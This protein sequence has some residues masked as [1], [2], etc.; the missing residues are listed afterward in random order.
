L[1]A[2]SL[3]DGQ[4]GQRTANAGVALHAHMNEV[5]H[6]CLLLLA[7]G[8]SLAVLGFATVAQQARNGLAEAGASL[9]EDAGPESRGHASPHPAVALNDSTL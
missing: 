1:G 4:V 3:D 7:M 5:T 8:A 9:I 2:R 6:I